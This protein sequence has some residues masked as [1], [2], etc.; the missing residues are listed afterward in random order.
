MIRKTR[1][2]RRPSSRFAPGPTSTISPI[3]SWPMRFA[4]FMPLD[5]V[6]VKVQVVSRS[7]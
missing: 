3:V 5:E 4:D 2:V 1:C 7:S 6:V